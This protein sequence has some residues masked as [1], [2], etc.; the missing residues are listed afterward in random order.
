MEGRPRDIV[1]RVLDLIA[2]AVM[3]LT[4]TL[5]VILIGI[6]SWLVYGRYVL[7]ATPTWVE[8]ASLLIVVWIAFLGAAVGIRR[9]THLSVDF[10]R[11]A[12]PPPLRK[13]LLLFAMLAMGAFGVLMAWYGYALFQRTVTRDIPLLGVSEGWRTVP[14]VASGILI[15]VFIADDLVRTLMGLPR[16]SD[17]QAEPLPTLAPDLSNGPL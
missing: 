6:F 7:N 1:S 12:M 10:I 16:A 5:M 9:G 4:G 13:A 15:A 14:V 8:Q 11:E 2:S 3:A 17:I